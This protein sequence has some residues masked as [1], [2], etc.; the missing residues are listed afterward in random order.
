MHQY[1]CKLPHL[2]AEN[3]WWD[4]KKLLLSLKF[5][6]I[7]IWGGEIKSLCCRRNPVWRPTWWTSSPLGLPCSH[8]PLAA[9]LMWCDV[10]D[11][12]L[13]KKLRFQKPGLLMTL[14]KALVFRCFTHLSRWTRSWPVQLQNTD[15][16]PVQIFF[17]AWWFF[18]FRSHHRLAW[19]IC[20]G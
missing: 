9:R 4:A 7:G 11:Y 6:V 2:K 15:P 13:K 17:I 3:F 20:I 16:L 12:G 5:I 14:L 19:N 8:K 10:V 1:R 18:F